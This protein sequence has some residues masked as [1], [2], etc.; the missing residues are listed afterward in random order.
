M[1]TTTTTGGTVE[2]VAC[3]H[4]LGEERGSSE[5]TRTRSRDQPDGSGD[6]TDVR[7]KKSPHGTEVLTLA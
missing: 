7:E 2:M 3:R 4:D 1:Y 6:T 5:R